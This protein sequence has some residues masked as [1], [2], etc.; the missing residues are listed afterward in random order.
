MTRALREP[1]SWLMLERYALGELGAEQ[2]AELER[3]LAGSE[4]ARAALAE[5]RE[6]LALPPLPAVAA[7]SAR[8][9]ARARKLSVRAAGVVAAAAVFMLVRMERDALPPARRGVKGG[10]LAIE[11]VGE[12]AGPAAT[13]FAQHERFKLLVTCPPGLAGRLSAVIYQDDAI[14]MPFA[15]GGP[16]ACGNRSPWPGAFAL[17][18][19]HPAQVCVRADGRAWPS[20]QAALEGDVVCITLRPGR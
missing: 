7:L 20:T 10:E 3:A 9:K 2:R 16:E 6:P 13:H 19:E 5:I 11:V 17:D 14:F 4:G 1:P 8:R 15:D 18:G 12:R